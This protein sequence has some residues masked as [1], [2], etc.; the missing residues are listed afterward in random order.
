MELTLEPIM[1]LSLYLLL[2]ILL[3][4]SINQHHLIQQLRMLTLT[5]PPF[6]ILFY[7]IQLSLE[8]FLITMISLVKEHFFPWSCLEFIHI[9]FL[10]SIILE[11]LLGEFK[12]FLIIL[13][14]SLNPILWIRI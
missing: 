4:L 14:I 13:R 10:K 8:N 2:S 1:Q 5:P 9:P 12:Q 7:L 11:S 6:S 3:L